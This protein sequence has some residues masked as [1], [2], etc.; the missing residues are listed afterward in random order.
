MLQTIECEQLVRSWLQ[1]ENQLMTNLLL[2]GPPG[3]GKTTLAMIM[4]KEYFRIHHQLVDIPPSCFY[5]INVSNYV[6]QHIK[7]IGEDGLLTNLAK[8]AN[9]FRKLLRFVII[10]E[11]DL[12][13]ETT[14]IGLCNAIKTSNQYTKYILISNFQYSLLSCM[15]RSITFIRMV[16]PT[17]ARIRECLQTI[18]R[19][20]H[21]DT[22]LHD[23]MIQAAMHQCVRNDM[24]MAINFLQT[25]IKDWNET[26][27]CNKK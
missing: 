22:S 12:L 23:S 16:P 6:S 8:N 25:G 11:V 24:R 9:P 14:Q 15:Y 27:I 3:C 4:I 19:N 17:T 5:L 2:V 26:S 13:D 20:E 10:D 18:L 1:N 21:I 7:F